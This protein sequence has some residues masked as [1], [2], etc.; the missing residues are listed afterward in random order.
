MAFLFQCDACKRQEPEVGHRATIV[1][2]TAFYREHE[3][4]GEKRTLELCGVCASRVLTEFELFLQ[5]IKA[6]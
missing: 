1:L 4:A 5:R 3:P 6:E 2:E